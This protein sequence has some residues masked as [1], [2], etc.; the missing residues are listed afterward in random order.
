MNI[1]ENAKNSTKQGDIGEA[2]AIYEYTRLGYA[3]SKPLND[4]CKYDLIVEKDNSLL[5]VQVKT[6]TYKTN[7]NGYSINLRTFG[8]NRSRTKIQKRK[9]G[10]WDIIFILTSNNRI[11]S[12]PEEVLG[13]VS[14]SIVVGNVKYKDYEI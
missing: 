9:K 14:N 13:N 8:G 6:S 12:I 2:R 7:E 4:S 1:F 11:W 10:D 5:R 3:V